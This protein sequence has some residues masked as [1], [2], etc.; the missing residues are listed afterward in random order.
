[1]ALVPGAPKMAKPYKGPALFFLE[2]LHFDLVNHNRCKGVD[3]CWKVSETWFPG[4]TIECSANLRSR[5]FEGQP[6]PTVDGHVWL[7]GVWIREYYT[8]PTAVV[9][10]MPPIASNQPEPLILTIGQ[11]NPKWVENVVDRYI[12]GILDDVGID[13]F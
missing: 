5:F 12:N 8:D 4:C 2:E 10:Y 1:M 6:N 13:L 9:I 11:P 3:V 7:E